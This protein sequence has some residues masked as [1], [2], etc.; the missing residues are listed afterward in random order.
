M[1]WE[2][3]TRYCAWL[4]VRSGR[5]VRLPSEAEWECACR[6]GEDAAF[7]FGDDDTE[8]GRY[9]WYDEN[10]E[11]TAHE[12]ATKRPNRW[13]LYDMHGN[14]WEWCEDV[15]HDYEDASD[16]GSAW[17]EGGSPDRITRGGCWS[18]PAWSCRSAYRNGPH[19]STSG[20]LLGFRPAF[21]SED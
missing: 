9:G 2:D 15:W 5:A 17:T 7:S 6:A 4:T 3:A 21:T 11:G 19:L 14:V 20:D 1:S 13:G 18:N 16:N 8:L 12:V 10:S